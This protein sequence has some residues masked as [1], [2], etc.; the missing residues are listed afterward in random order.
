M[1]PVPRKRVKRSGLLEGIV[2]VRDFLKGKLDKHGGPVGLAKHAVA[3]A[4]GQGAGGGGGSHGTVPIPKPPAT[5]MPDPAAELKAAFESLPKEPDKDGYRAVAPSKLLGE[6]ELNTFKVGDVPVACFRIDGKI[7]VIDDE[8][9][10]ENGPI[11]EGKLDGFVVTCP[12]HD[13]RYDVRNGNCL[14]DPERRLSCFAVKEA[15][16][17]IWV[18]PITREGTKSRGGEHDDGLKVAEIT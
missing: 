14:T 13:W 4:S 1:A 15:R 3:K 12:Y 6:G 17:F 10:H 11:G 9:A 18:G 16:G 7:Y 2:G 8:C 5:P